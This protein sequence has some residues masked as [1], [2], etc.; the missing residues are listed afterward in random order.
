MKRRGDDGA[1]AV[2]FGLFLSVMLMLGL[3]IYPLGAAF[4]D[5]ILLGRA[6]NDGLRFAT[7]TPNSA[8]YGS[9]GRRPSADDIKNE[10]VRAYKADG[11]SGLTTSDISVTPATAPGQTVTIHISKDDGGGIFSGLLQFAHVTNSASI[12]VTVDASG[13]EE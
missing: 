3:I 7:A 9:S 13:R 10:V 2:E 12:T 8:A 1:A 11:G 4:Y 5:K 6:L